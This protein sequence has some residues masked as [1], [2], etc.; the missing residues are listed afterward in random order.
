MQHFKEQER[1]SDDEVEF[2]DSSSDATIEET[3]QHPY[4][5]FPT[6]GNVEAAAN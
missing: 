3:K 6:M 1:S 4:E 5:R 2:K